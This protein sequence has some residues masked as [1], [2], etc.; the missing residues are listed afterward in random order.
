[1]PPK[2]DKQA[3]ID[4]KTLSTLV[5]PW[6]VAL[7]S[8][9]SVYS[10]V[11]FHDS[12]TRLKHYIRP[13]ERIGGQMLEQYKLGRMRPH[14]VAVHEFVNLRNQL[15]KTTRGVISPGALA[16]SEYLKEKAPTFADLRTKYASEGSEQ[17]IH[18]KIMKKSIETNSTVTKQ[19]MRMRWFGITGIGLFPGLL[20]VR[21]YQAPD[22]E[23]VYEAFRVGSELVGG[24][25][26]TWRGVPALWAACKIKFPKFPPKQ[27]L[28]IHVVFGIGTS[29]V[30]SMVGS[31]VADKFL[32][33]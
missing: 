13:L 28:L 7:P 6:A 32:K 29:T 27:V 25:L 24:S 4:E 5:P 14:D 18:E 20:G 17:K 3:K 31:S 10:T 9:L 30:G 1:M 26:A 12:N 8:S 33:S 11:T 2:E 16:L 15:M 19:A 22:E 23:R 21:L